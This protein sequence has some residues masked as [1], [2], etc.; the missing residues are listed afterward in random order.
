MTI[1]AGSGDET[2]A[3][4]TG[5]QYIDPLGYDWS[6]SGYNGVSDLVKKI[7]SEPILLAPL[8]RDE[9]KKELKERCMSDFGKP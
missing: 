7:L 2:K 6:Q 1:R 3:P 4:T 5:S 8:S 9:M